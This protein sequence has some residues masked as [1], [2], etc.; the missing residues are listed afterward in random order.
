MEFVIIVY[1]YTTIA[2][3]KQLTW[4]DL[5]FIVFHFQQEKKTMILQNLK[6]EAKSYF[7]IF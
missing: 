4:C 3:Y 6:E 5:Y 1:I 7:L 2:V